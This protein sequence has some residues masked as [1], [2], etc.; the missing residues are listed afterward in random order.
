MGLRNVIT[1]VCVSDDGRRNCCDGINSLPASDGGRSP[2]N[3][4]LEGLKDTHRRYLL[5]HLQ[6]EDPSTLDEAARFVAACDQGCDPADVPSKILDR[7]KCEL[8]HT[9]LP[10]LTDLNFIDYD[11]RTGA[12]RLR[13][14]P[15]RLADFLDLTHLVD[16]ID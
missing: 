3:R 16:D 12:L 6:E 2:L 11:D 15:N 8:Y 14:P 13:D 10:K 4:I 1:H 5:Y 9:H 7:I